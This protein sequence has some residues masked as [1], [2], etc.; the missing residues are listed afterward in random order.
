MET[1]VVS[2]RTPSGDGV[3]NGKPVSAVPSVKKHHF[4][5][6][7]FIVLVLLCAFGVIMLFSASYYYAQSQFGDGLYFV[8]KQLIFLVIGFGALL[9]LS[10]LKYTFY[11]KI[12]LVSYLAL[13][14][15]L[16]L[17]LVVGKS[18]Q[19]AQ[20]WIPIGGFQFQ[21]A[22]FAKFIMVVVMANFM[23]TKK[24]D[25]S[26]FFSGMLPLLVYLV[27]PCVLI[28]LQPNLS[29]VIILCL[30]A[31][32][33]FFIGGTKMIHR[34]MLLAAGAAAILV[35]VLIEPYR[36]SRLTTFFDPW[37]DPSGS[38]YQ[39]IQSL[40]AFGNGGLFGQGINASRQKLLFLPYRESDFVLSIIGEELGFVG[41]FLLLAAYLFVIYRGIRIA[42]RCRRFGSLLAAG[43]TGV[44]AIQ[45]LINVGVVTNAL[46]ATGQTLPFISAGGTSL[47]VF[48]AAMGI[49]LNV[50]RYTEVGKLNE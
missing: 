17:T 36:L 1:N 50:S 39:T 24:N 40:Y 9:G 18:A 22:E 38:G 4:D 34:L 26:K 43:I 20:R 14:A 21:P 8:K 27:I 19:G 7:L 25:M 35:L 15:L 28:V 6:P 2:M 3:A 45:V 44:L 41:C 46:P 33:M 37:K 11:R 10:H 42:M 16:V 13:I 48:L 47:V 5:F 29:M 12:A 32:F 49:L 30:T 31:Y 23:T